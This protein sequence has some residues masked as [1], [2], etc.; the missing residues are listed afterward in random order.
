MQAYTN[1]V[2]KNRDLVKKSLEQAGSVLDLKANSPLFKELRGI[3]T[4]KREQL[5][6]Q[7]A[8]NSITLNVTNVNDAPTVAAVSASGNEDDASITV[9]LS[10]TDIDGT[11]AGYTVATL[12]TAS[13][14]TYGIVFVSDATNAVGTSSASAASLA[15]IPATLPGAPTIGTATRGRAPSAGGSRPRCCLQRS[16]LCGLSVQ[17]LLQGLKLLHHHLLKL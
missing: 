5:E 14:Y 10:A 11:V 2:Q 15:T 17:L 7:L 16:D 12:P 6:R 4:E 3:V 1:S 9:A 13:S 8:A